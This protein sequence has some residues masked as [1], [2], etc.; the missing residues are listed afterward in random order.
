MITDD[1]KSIRE[2]GMHRILPA[3]SEQY[4][5]R[6]FHVPQLNFSAADDIYII[7]SQKTIVTEYSNCY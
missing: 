5:I 4:G 2:L 3:R 1:R 7:D 6:Q